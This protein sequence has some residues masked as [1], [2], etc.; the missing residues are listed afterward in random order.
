MKPANAVRI[1][2]YLWSIRLFKTR[3]QATKA[4]SEGKVKLKDENFK[5]SRTVQIGEVYAIKNSERRI[6]I[7]VTAIINKRVKYAEAILNYY[8]VSTEEDKQFNTNK[9]SSSFFTGK[10]QSKVGRPTKKNARDLSEFFGGDDDDEDD[11]NEEATMND[12]DITQKDNDNESDEQNW[13]KKEEI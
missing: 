12:L 6:S 13:Q 11:E 9:L 8:D 4:I 5:P 2:L 7:Q 10:R 1:D 3:T